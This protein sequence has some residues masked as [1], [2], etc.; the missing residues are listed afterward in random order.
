MKRNSKCTIITIASVASIASVGALAGVISK[1]LKKSLI[2]NL[3]NKGF[4][5]FN[6]RE[7]CSQNSCSGNSYDEVLRHRKN[8]Y[9]Q[10]VRA[11]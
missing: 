10:R 2:N 3:N 11:Y 5:K 7:K 4:N 6:G 8:R 9:H 1:I